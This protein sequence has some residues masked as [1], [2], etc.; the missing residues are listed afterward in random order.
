MSKFPLLLAGLLS[1]AGV[2]ACTSSINSEATNPTT[3]SSIDSS[4][5]A[6]DSPTSAKNKTAQNNYLMRSEYWH[7]LDR[8]FINTEVKHLGLKKP[9]KPA[10][11]KEFGFDPDQPVEWFNTT[12]GQRIADILLSFQTPSGGWSKRTDMGSHPRRAGEAFGVE[13]KYIPTFDNGATS[14]QVHLLAK[15]YSATNNP[16]YAEGFYKGLTLIL[17]AQY[18]NGGWPQTY[19]LVGGYH[20]HITYNDSL[21]ADLMSLLYRVSLGTNEFAFVSSEVRTKAAASLQKGLECV[22]K[23]QVKVNDTLTIWGAQHDVQTLQPAKARAYEPAS[24]STA[25]SVAMLQLLMELE[26]PSTQL[27]NSVHSAMNWYEQNK[28]I[29]Y[30]WQRGDTDMI[31][32]AEAPPMWSRFVE[33]G[34]NRP[35]FGDRDQSIYYKI[36]E[37]SQERREGYGWFTTAPNKALKKYQKWAKKFPRG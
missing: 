34:T 35:I 19:P 18:A 33:I 26:N 32:D 13:K 1:L 17:E 27:I 11:T 23:T 36:S 22:L 2:Y 9:N 16:N 14:T 5:S 7:Q 12:E 6:S 20:D 28:I 25:E 15:A 10:Y 24:L 37:I 8:D 3:N 21:M 4:N 30:R 29:G 31:A